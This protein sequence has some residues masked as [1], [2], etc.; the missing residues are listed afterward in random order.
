[1]DNHQYSMAGSD[2]TIT[3]P[4]FSI[5]KSVGDSIK[6]YRSNN[7]VVNITL[8]AGPQLDGDLDNGVISHEYTHGISNRLTEDQT[9]QPV[10]IIKNPVVWEKAGE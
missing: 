3:I 4:A 7:I 8:K 10:L 6:A 9:T 2:N 5:L 1:M